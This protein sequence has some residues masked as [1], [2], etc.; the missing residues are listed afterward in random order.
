LDGFMTTEYMLFMD[1]LGLPRL[2][3]GRW[4]KDNKNYA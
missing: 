1:N 2:C 4:L 3:K